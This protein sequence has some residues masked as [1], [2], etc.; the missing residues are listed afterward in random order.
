MYRRQAPASVHAIL[1][2][3]MATLGDPLADLGYLVATY[4]DADAVS[5]PLELTTVT[6]GEG[7][8]RRA[9]LVER[10]V[11]RTGADVSTLSW[12]ET[13]ALWK[14]AVFCEAIY[15]RWLD[16][17]RPGDTFA[18]TL[19]HGVPVLLAQAAARAVS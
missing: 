8:P 9:D 12:Y 19:A 17:E 7:Y 14:A 1:D 11:E 10:Y 2:W 13:L 6:R 18:P 3:E 5:T 4:A 15:T 16:G